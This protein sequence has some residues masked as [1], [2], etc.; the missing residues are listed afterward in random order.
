MAFACALCA[1]HA[2][3]MAEFGDA[4]GGSAAIA[5]SAPTPPPTAAP[6]TE[7]QAYLDAQK[8]MWVWHHGKSDPFKPPFPEL[9][10]GKA[11]KSQELQPGEK[12]TAPGSDYKRIALLFRG[13]FITL[14]AR[15]WG[16]GI[17]DSTARGCTC[18]IPTPIV[19]M[20]P[21]LLRSSF[22]K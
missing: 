10:N 4:E 15:V 17:G 22:I 20:Q 1:A 7:L 13:R 8:P 11:T 18:A 12:G 19:G 21:K 9:C 2:V 5:T 3:V 6:T 16:F 14:R